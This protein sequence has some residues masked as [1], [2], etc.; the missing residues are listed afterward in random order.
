MRFLN[1]NR[2][3][4]NFVLAS[5]AL[6]LSACSVGV[7]TPAS[8]STPASSDEPSISARP[9]ASLSP[10]PEETSTPTPTP[11]PSLDPAI[12]A[13]LQNPN[14]Q[15][16]LGPLPPEHLATISQTEA[17]QTAFTLMNAPGPALYVA[18]GIDLRAPA[19]PPVWLIIVK[20]PEM[21]PIPVGPGCPEDA[22]SGCTRTWAV[23]DYAGALIS[24][25]TGNMV[26]TFATMRVV[27]APS[28][29][30]N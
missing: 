4:A 13:I 29:L 10:S 1:D 18:H 12:A 25:V 3:K 24:D 15:L 8:P 17:E 19:Q 6:I 16:S 23:N 30:V 22:P 9:V 28:I 20:V 27:P 11:S 21:E 5:T 2:H 26:R 14:E 7:G